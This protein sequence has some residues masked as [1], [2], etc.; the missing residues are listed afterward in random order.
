MNLKTTNIVISFGVYYYPG[1]MLFCF[2]ANITMSTSCIKKEKTVHIKYTR[3]GQ[4][5]VR[6]P[7]AALESNLDES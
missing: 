4:N 3:C 2:S 5:E 7:R 6:E 1:K